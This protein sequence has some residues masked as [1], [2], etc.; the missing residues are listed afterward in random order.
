MP[1]SELFTLLFAIMQHSMVDDN[2]GEEQRDSVA[3]WSRFTTNKDF[4]A[5]REPADEL[6]QKIICFQVLW[7]GKNLWS[8]IKIEEILLKSLIL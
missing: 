3:I 6:S 5:F 8:I 1:D 4:F 2:R 7:T